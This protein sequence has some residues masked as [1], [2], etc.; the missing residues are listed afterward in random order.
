MSD[1]IPSIQNGLTSSSAA[2]Y[3]PRF[4]IGLLGVLALLTGLSY[5][6]LRGEAFKPGVFEI[7]GIT[8]AVV[9]LSTAL[10]LSE[11]RRLMV[12]YTLVIAGLA[13]A[14]LPYI[15]DLWANLE[16]ATAEYAAKEIP[17]P[18]LIKRVASNAGGHDA[19]GFRNDSIPD[20]ADIVGIGDS[21]T[22]GWN[23]TRYEAWPSALGTLAAKTTYNMG[24]N[25]F[26][27]AE[28]W[29]LTGDALDQFAPETIVVALY[30]GNDLYDAYESIY[31]YETEAA[32][33]F[34]LPAPDP[35]LFVDLPGIQAER[36]GWDEGIKFKSGKISTYFTPIY[37][38]QA[39]NLDEARIA[40]GLRLTG[41]ILIDIAERTRAADVGLIVVL[42]PT[43][44]T[45]YAGVVGD[46]Q[47]PAFALEVSL[48]AQ[49]RTQLLTALD[50]HGITVV[51]CLP[52]LQTALESGAPVFNRDK[53][54][55]L[56]ANGYKVVAEAIYP[57]LTATP[58][59]SYN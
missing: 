10:P 3:A 58:D 40:E 7:A 42:L 19:N 11:Q 46:Q 49:A 32:A 45:V 50:A 57:V 1:E 22:W 43:K 27:P 48:E 12:T 47:T 17:D 25:G 13:L 21:F 55:H 36:I 6:V 29:F 2:T 31:L 41:A 37:R 20:H 52:A 39:L 30:L 14:G 9:G 5:T 23:A 59:A 18:R 33:R 24:G 15:F 4:F 51:D 26:G 34:R 54:G 16:P 38:L 53:D 8:A 56:N 44:E 28:Y 35:A